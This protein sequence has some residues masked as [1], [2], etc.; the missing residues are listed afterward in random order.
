MKI[1]TVGLLGFGRFGRMV[2]HYLRRHKQLR[3]FDCDPARL[4]GL[5]EAAPLEKT[6]ASQLLLLCVPISSLEKL[7]RQMAPRL[8][9]GQIVLDTSSVKVRPVAWML[10]HLPEG[11]QILGTHP[12]FGPDSA[13]ESIAGLKIALCPVRIEP[14]A[15]QGI[16]RYLEGLH[17]VVIEATPEEHDRQIAQSQAIFHLIAQTLKRLRWEGQA[18]S[19]PGPEAF[20]RLAKTVQHDTEQLFRDLELLN[21]Y[22]ERCRQ[23][24]LTAILELEREL[25]AALKSSAAP[26]S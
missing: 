7:C 1:E 15:Y 24:F 3:V 17:L 18:I 6:L 16:R 19:T 22:A 25:A 20:Y 11:V 26:V 12:L 4:Q 2:H 5:S 23:E 10:R 14:E 13:K 21:P 9:P 8:Q